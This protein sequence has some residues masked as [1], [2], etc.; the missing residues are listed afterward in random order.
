MTNIM[1]KV[2]QREYA[3]C[4]Q[5]MRHVEC[6][7]WWGD[8]FW[9]CEEKEEEVSMCWCG[10]VEKENGLSRVLCT[11]SV[12]NCI[13]S[14]TLTHSF[15]P[16]LALI[17]YTVSHS[18]VSF[19]DSFRIQLAIRLKHFACLTQLSSLFSAI[20]IIMN[21]CN[22]ICNCCAA[23]RLVCP[24]LATGNFASFAFS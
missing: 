22:C 24:Q 4:W 3:K 20:L 11:S 5:T 8:W 2:K 18:F 16:S 1:G 13:H 14:F 7:H 19:V 10:R 6:C 21:A 15:S 23:P 12:D 17:Q 9:V